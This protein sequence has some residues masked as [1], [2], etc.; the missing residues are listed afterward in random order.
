MQP[1]RSVGGIPSGRLDD[2]IPRR[3]SVVR[4][5]NGFM[6]GLVTGESAR[7]QKRASGGRLEMREILI[8]RRRTRLAQG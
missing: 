6:E 1:T 5:L 8:K 3:H 2:G 7:I 4:R